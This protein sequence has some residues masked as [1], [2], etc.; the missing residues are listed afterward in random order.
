M[1]RRSVSYLRLANYHSIDDVVDLESEDIDWI[2]GF[3]QTLSPSFVRLVIP[4][5]PLR[6]T[7]YKVHNG[8]ISTN[9]AQLW[10]HGRVV[11]GINLGLTLC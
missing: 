5:V 1:A 11:L 6:Q 8:I 7:S 3:Y 10:F 4:N 9:V 2:E